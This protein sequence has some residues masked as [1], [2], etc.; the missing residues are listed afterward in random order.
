MKSGIGVIAEAAVILPEVAQGKT[1]EVPPM[2][3]ITEG[4]EIGVV[5]SNNNGPASRLEKTMKLL[6]QANY[7]S[8]MFDDMDGAYFAEAIIAKREGNVIQVGDD[9]GARV[10]I[11]IKADSTGILVDAAADI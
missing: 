4:A 1:V 3:G 2:G 11:S 7:V 5:G 10:R 8:D 6:H 9:I